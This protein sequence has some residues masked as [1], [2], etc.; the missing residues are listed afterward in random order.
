MSKGRVA[1]IGAGVSG[2]TCGIVLQERGYDVE[3]KADKDTGDTTS[4]VA[5]AIWYPYHVGDEADEDA[6]AAKADVDKWAR[7]SYRRLQ[8]L[9]GLS[10]SGVSMIEFRFESRNYIPLPNWEVPRPRRLLQKDLAAGYRS[11]YAV[12]V[13]VMETPPY[14]RYLREWFGIDRIKSQVKVE[15]LGDVDPNFKV[16][17][18]CCGIDGPRFS[19]TDPSIMKPGRGVIVYGKSSLEYAFLDTDDEKEGKLT[20]I[21]PRRQNGDCV[22]GGSDDLI[23]NWNLDVTDKEK[24]AI[25][26]RCR[27]IDPSLTTTEPR[28][29]LRP[30]RAK[31]VR[32]GREEIDGRTVIHNYGHGGAGLTLSWGCALDVADLVDQ[33]FGLR[34]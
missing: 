31:G 7:T 16:I 13:P 34:H 5:S 1:I 23:T 22:F 11:G 28:A 20:Y 17:V 9:I 21:V 2:L 26:E 4:A 12:D 29:G 24:N 3:L 19:K 32:L 15:Q 18:N 10:D 33:A 27:Q 25:I 8:S 14:L 6:K 30:L